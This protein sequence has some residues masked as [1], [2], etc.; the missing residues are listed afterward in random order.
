MGLLVSALAVP[1]LATAQ[2]V[3]YVAPG[4]S[5]AT[6]DGSSGRPYTLGAAV[7]AVRGRAAGVSVVLRGG[8]Y[9]LSDPLVLTDA[10]SGAAGRPVTYVSAPGERAR[11]LGGVE[12]P[13]QL[14]RAVKTGE[15]W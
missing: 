12:L 7:K 6:G 15:G 10:D 9:V 13:A 5:E 4:A 3:V 2:R 8:D 11:L 14:F 1:F